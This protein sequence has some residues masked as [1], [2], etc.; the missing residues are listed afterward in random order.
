MSLKLRHRRAFGLLTGLLLVPVVYGLSV[1]RPPR[2][3]AEHPSRLQPVTQ[4]KS[5]TQTPNAC[6]CEEIPDL[7]SRHHEVDAAIA[8]LLNQISELEAGERVG[9][10]VTFT[11]TR[12]DQFI[13]LNIKEAMDK[14]YEQQAHRANDTLGFKQDCSSTIDSGGATGCLW[15][16]LQINEATR[17]RICEENRNTLKNTVR[18]I[19]GIDWREKYNLLAFANAELS[20]YQAERDFIDQQLRAL[21]GACKFSNWTGTIKVTFKRTVETSKTFPQPGQ[22]PTAPSGNDKG[23]DESTE[24][25]TIIVVDGRAFGSNDIHLFKRDDQNRSGNESCHGGGLKPKLTPFTSNQ[26]TTSE[27]NGHFYRGTSYQISFNGG[28]VKVSVNLP[29]G[30]GTGTQIY[31]S[32]Y[33]GECG[34]KEPVN[35]SNPLYNVNFGAPTT[36]AGRGKGLPTD[37]RLDGTYAPDPRLLELEGFKQTI[38]ETMEWHLRRARP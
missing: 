36:S 38:T 4:S 29:T 19:V 37:N 13:R 15:Q 33:S 18:D 14:A 8:V 17:Q 10:L 12:Y 30:N 24:T 26:H 32:E 16:S 3:A 27:V 7:I 22:P 11:Q 2:S 25:A 34:N 1:V 28:E 31:H 35:K 9:R 20:A 5:S 6:N 23:F 21:Y